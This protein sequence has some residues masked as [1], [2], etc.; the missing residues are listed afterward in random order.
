MTGAN[1]V[2]PLQPPPAVNHRKP[3]PTRNAGQRG[4]DRVGRT[5]DGVV[6]RRRNRP[7]CRGEH[8]NVIAPQHLA[9]PT[10]A[11]AGP[12]AHRSARTQA[13]SPPCEAWL[14]RLA[15]IW[16]RHCWLNHPPR[17]RTFLSVICR[18]EQYQARSI[19]LV[20]QWHAGVDR[21]SQST[22]ASLG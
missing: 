12:R 13:A 11:R 10:V 21:A 5:G 17:I 16:C 3:G 1:Q 2:T 20:G 8:G 22:S 9:P 14:A 15:N 6:C 18:T 4:C 19:L 7:L